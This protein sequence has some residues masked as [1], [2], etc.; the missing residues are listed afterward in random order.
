MALNTFYLLEFGLRNVL[1]RLSFVFIGHNQA[2]QL[3]VICCQKF[4]GDLQSTHRSTWYRTVFKLNSQLSLT[5]LGWAGFTHLLSTLHRNF[6]EGI[7]IVDWILWTCIAKW[8]ADC[9]NSRSSDGTH[10]EG[11]K[12]IEIQ[13]PAEC[14]DCVGFRI[15]ACVWVWVWV[16]TCSLHIPDA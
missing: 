8:Y 6:S 10:F 1:S 7:S 9:M 3:I 15:Y 11:E 2:Q 14:D 12:V 13:W 16:C 5:W 4:F